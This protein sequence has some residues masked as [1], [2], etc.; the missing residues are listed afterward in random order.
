MLS[1]HYFLV[2][3]LLLYFKKYSNTFIQTLE[4]HLSTKLSEVLLLIIKVGMFLKMKYR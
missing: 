1:D 3:Y 2:E 4:C